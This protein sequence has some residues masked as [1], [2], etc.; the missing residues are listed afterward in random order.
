MKKLILKNSQDFAEIYC[1]VGIIANHR[2]WL[3]NY[4]NS[5]ELKGRWLEFWDFKGEKSGF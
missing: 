1:L 3:S 5:I 4:Y 2:Y